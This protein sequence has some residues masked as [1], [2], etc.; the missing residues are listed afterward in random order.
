MADITM[1]KM[2]FDMQEGTIV[3]WLKKPGDQI[4]RGE[5]IAEIETDK[6][7]I[8]IEAFDS[9]T[10]SE[11]VVQEGQVAAVNAVI[12]RLGNGQA[13]PASEAK[14]AEP[15]K[16]EAP[17]APAPA[18]GEAKPAAEG[19]SKAA[20]GQAQA[21]EP[22]GDVRASPLARRIARENSVDLRQVTGT[23]PSGRVV[24]DDVQAF[25]D[26][27]KARAEAPAPQ[28]APAT[29]AAP[30]AAPATPAAPTPAAQP[31]Q[32]VP[33]SGMR[34]A[35][36]RRMSQS[37]DQA[38]HIFV[39]IDVDMTAALALRKQVNEGQ[40]KE[41]HVS[42]N[43]IVLKAA[44]TALRSFP[45]VNASYTDSGLEMHPQVNISI[46]VAL[47]NGLIAPVIT[48]C[49]ERSLGSIARESKR[50]VGLARENKLTPDNIQGGTFT[51][52]NL[53][54]YGIT[55]FT[56][57]VTLPQAA[58]LSVGTVQRVPVFKDD[59]DEVI[60]KQIMTLNVAADHRVIDG[61]E[62]ARFIV[63]VKRLL[64]HPMQL[65]VG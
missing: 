19:E 33:L 16:E 5:P 52:S 12:A 38:P 11:I 9:G 55:Q 25:V 40:P 63:E 62:A 30:S 46:A 58:A 1:P 35:I 43:D 57:I 41:A 3:K 54:M 42:V 2:G 14:P 27:G 28:A 65:L 34:K 44:G 50:L 13:Q 8:E 53:G 4:T 31:G 22:E 61:A 18:A 26:S 21:A 17:A 7:T 60:A 48:N 49:D 45:N 20:N 15:A 51:V 37:W 24:R 10:L 32:V 29:P 36:A 6:V 59:S 39:S 56:S 47:D 23:G 64:E